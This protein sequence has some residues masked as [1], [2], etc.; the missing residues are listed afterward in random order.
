[1]EGVLRVGIDIGSTTI[2]LI[3]LDQKNNILAEH[4][5]RHFSEIPAA[6]H[7]NLLRL[8]EVVGGEPFSFALTGSA[9]MGIAQRLHLPFDGWFMDEPSF[10]V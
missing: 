6:L 8:R 3:V 2:K 10:E 9:G 1:M 7:E 4:Y 5:A